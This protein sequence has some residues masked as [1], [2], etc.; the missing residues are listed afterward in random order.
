[1]CFDGRVQE[2]FST[3]EQ[4]VEAVDYE[5]ARKGRSVEA[6]ARPEAAWRAGRADA[7]R[8]DLW[9]RIAGK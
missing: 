3:I 9:R 1:V 2:R 4:A 8:L 5:L 7:L 6:S